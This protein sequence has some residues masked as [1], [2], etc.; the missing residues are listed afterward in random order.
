MNNSKTTNKKHPNI[1]PAAVAMIKMEKTTGGLW[2]NEKKTR[3]VSWWAAGTA[4]QID[5]GL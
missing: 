2:E 4:G 3:R 5:K 1:T